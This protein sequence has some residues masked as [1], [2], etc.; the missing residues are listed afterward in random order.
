ML[1]PFF[2]LFLF[3]SLETKNQNWDE[4]IDGPRVRSS[5][6]SIR[7]MVWTKA[8]MRL[9]SQTLDVATPEWKGGDARH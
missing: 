9:G 2:G 8:T 7:S 4:R 1:L 5:I 6:S 3:Q